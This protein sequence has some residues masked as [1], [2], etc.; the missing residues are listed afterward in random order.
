LPDL[1]HYWMPFTANRAFKASP[2]L[3]SRA[4]GV[5]LYTP[6]GRAVLDGCSGL[7][8]VA[9]GHGRREIA[10]AVHAQLCSLDYTSPF[11][12]GHPGAFQLAER[13]CGILP[14]GL[15]RVFFVNSGSE[16]V[17]TALKIALAY[18]RARGDAG[19]HVFVSRERAY[20][21]VNLGGTS[22][23]G[24]VR[25]REA[26]G[27]ASV[28][29][30]VHMRHT[31]LPENRFVLGQ[32]EHGADLALDL[33]RCVDTLGAGAI[34][35]CV[36][37]PVAG[38]VGCYVPP[39]GYLERLRKIC[40][41]HGILLIL[42][43]VLCGFGRLGAPFSSD[44]FGVAPDILTFAKAITNGAQPMGGVAVRQSIHDAIVD[45]AP[46]GAIEF[47]HGYTWS[48]HPA[49]CAAGLA[50]LDI[51]ERE[52]LFARAALLAPAFLDR[53]AQLGSTR[54]VLDVRGIGLLGAVDVEP[55]AGRPG[56]RGALLARR[57]FDAG[58]HLKFTGDTALIAPPLVAQTQDLDRLFGI[59][60]DTL[61]RG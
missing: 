7:F 27:V 34:A 18:H 4:E 52:G 38:S 36:V 60:G 9:A 51:F 48:G 59:L 41:R 22:L 1:R 29:H 50:T 19:R 16:A 23:S 47:F 13:L 58:L 2:R 6:D 56:A 45:A 42:D 55:I 54:G 3:V 8:C 37:E 43:E 40:D 32:A 57:L 33:Q 53:L 24:L 21:G 20:H 35:A 11:Q 15:S 5:T 14:E 25:N 31:L 39:R 28:P 46:D 61:A 26:F 10:E 17:D 12:L 44:L 30:V 49:A